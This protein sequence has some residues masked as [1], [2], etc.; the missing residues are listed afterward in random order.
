M[1][2]VY[3]HRVRHHRQRASKMGLAFRQLRNQPGCEKDLEW[4]MEGD[5]SLAI[6]VVG[7]PAESDKR[8]AF[9]WRRI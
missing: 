3:L 2:L 1:I 7:Q 9:S 5:F 4:Q 8:G 6:L